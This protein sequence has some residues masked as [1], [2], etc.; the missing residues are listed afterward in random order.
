MVPRARFELARARLL[1][2]VGV[3]IS[4]ATWAFWCVAR[5]SNPDE[6]GFEPA[7]SAYCISDAYGGAGRIRTYTELADLRVTA[8][9]STE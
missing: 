8:A 7:M 5:D 1:R 4:I 6:A 9:C 3:P 2:P